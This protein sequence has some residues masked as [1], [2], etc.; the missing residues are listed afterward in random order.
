MHDQWVIKNYFFLI[1]HALQDIDHNFW[2]EGDM[3]FFEMSKNVHLILHWLMHSKILF[4]R[5]ILKCINA[6][7][8][9]EVIKNYF[10]KFFRALQDIDHNFWCEKETRKFLNDKKVHLI[11]RQLMYSKILCVQVILKTHQCVHWWR[12]G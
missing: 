11:L 12:C 10:F 6:H 7:M 8:N 2:C 9:D 3:E 5:V 4:M 1:F